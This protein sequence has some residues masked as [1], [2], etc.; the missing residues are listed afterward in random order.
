MSTHFVLIVIDSND[1]HR[2]A[3]WWSEALGWPI[4]LEEDEEV[5]VEPMDE[6]EDQVP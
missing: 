2:L 6:L 5:V 4:T 3:R 1:P